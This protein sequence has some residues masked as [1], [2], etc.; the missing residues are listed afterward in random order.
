MAKKNQIAARVS[1]GKAGGKNGIFI[2]VQ[3]NTILAGI[4]NVAK[5]KAKVTLTDDPGAS[6]SQ[7]TKAQ[8]YLTRMV[9]QDKHPGKTELL[10]ASKATEVSLK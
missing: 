1:T 8:K 7:N 2:N 10:T 6:N 3:G 9:K 4:I 5:G